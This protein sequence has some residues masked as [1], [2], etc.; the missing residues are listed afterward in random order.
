MTGP[1]FIKLTC[2]SDPNYPDWT[3]LETEELKSCL[4]CL[5]RGIAC[6]GLAAFIY[7]GLFP[8]FVLACNVNWL[9]SI[10]SPPFSIIDSFIIPSLSENI[11][12]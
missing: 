2:I 5:Y 6:S 4:N 9:I 7:D 11:L 12:S 1:S 8:Y 3:L 10:I